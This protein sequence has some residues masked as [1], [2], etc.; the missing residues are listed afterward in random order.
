M[1]DYE[2]DVVVDS[3]GYSF[4]LPIAGQLCS[5]NLIPSSRRNWL[6]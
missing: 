4:A 2:H 1:R 3:F 5:K 6:S